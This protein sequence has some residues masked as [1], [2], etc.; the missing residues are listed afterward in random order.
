[1]K[2][3]HTTTRRLESQLFSGV[4]FVLKKMTEGRRIDL[5]TKLAPH[6]SRVREI[7]REQAIIDKVDENDRDVSKWIALQEEFDSI[8]LEQVNPAW[9]NWGVKL[10]DGL[11]ADGNPLGLEDWKD[12]PSALVNEVVEAVKAE[13]ELN[14]TERKNSESPTTS[15]EVVG[16]TP[17][18]TIVATAG[19]KDSGEIETAGLISHTK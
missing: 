3:N 2:Y 14:G 4:S 16:Q 7:M 5:R 6:N 1:M 15:G 17:K 10:I 11:E 13:A 12:W 19:E 18:L 8:M 9:I